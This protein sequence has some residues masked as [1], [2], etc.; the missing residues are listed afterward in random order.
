MSKRGALNP[1]GPRRRNV[2]QTPPRNRGSISPESWFQ[3]DHF[4]F[5]PAGSGR[6]SGD[7]K[8]GKAIGVEIGVFT[9]LYSDDAEVGVSVLNGAN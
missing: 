2:S 8:V 4:Q 7:A 1:I 3:L 5:R 9:V 6:F